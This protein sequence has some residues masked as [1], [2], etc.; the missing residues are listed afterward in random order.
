[1]T[2][3]FAEP[4]KFEYYE[5]NKEPILSLFTFS[6]SRLTCC[7]TNKTS[8]YPPR[9]DNHCWIATGLRKNLSGL[10]ERITENQMNK[11]QITNPLD[12][13]RGRVPG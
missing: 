10:V 11:D 8:C 4:L 12:A 6:C 7:R 2:Y 1:M 13:I 5:E 3:I 9:F